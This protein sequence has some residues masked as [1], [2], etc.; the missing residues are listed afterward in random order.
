ML[1]A[2]RSVALISLTLALGAVAV[3]ALSMPGT[4]PS[5]DRARDAQGTM[6]DGLVG[7]KLDEVALA[8]R[9][10]AQAHRPELRT[11]AAR[12]Q[13]DASR[14]LMRLDAAH[15]QIFGSPPVDAGG[16]M[17]LHGSMAIPG[18]PAPAGA[19]SR[20][21]AGDDRA[22]LDALIAARAGAA[23]LVR[24]HQEMLDPEV[25][26]LVQRGAKR[27]DAASTALN[28]LRIRWYGRSSPVLDA[29]VSASGE[30][31]GMDMP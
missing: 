26:R 2:A 22:F 7:A 18:I 25:D 28:A 17:P 6:I 21:E 19:P 23:T 12:T 9:A 8:R 11:A 10:A 20:I 14:T 13:L 4:D 27:D 29:P 3:L 30:H 1:R 5:S 16:G 15:R 24:Q 31:R